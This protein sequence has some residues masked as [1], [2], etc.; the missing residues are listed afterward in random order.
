MPATRHPSTSRA[1]GCRT[2]RRRSGA[3]RT[4]AALGGVLLLAGCGSDADSAGTAPPTALTTGL[5]VADTAAPTLESSSGTA[6]RPRPSLP[7]RTDDTAGDTTGASAATDPAATEPI[8]TAPP[9]TTVAPAT[10]TAPPTTAVPATAAAPATTTG[11]TRPSRTIPGSVPTSVPGSLPA[12]PR[13]GYAEGDPGTVSVALSEPVAISG[14]TPVPVSCSV[15]ALTYTASFSGAAV[16][17]GVSVSA[18]ITAAPYRGPGTYP[19]AGSLS[20]TLAD[21]Q[22]VTV[23]IAAQVTVA[24]DLAGSVTLDVTSTSGV[25]VTGSLVWHCSA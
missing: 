2:T 19:G 15:T 12:D 16:T 21:G 23:P 18:S 13:A 7:P 4:L 6:S 17:A 1:P 11:S 25:S 22:N 20:V 3:V 14:W 5:S 9:A 8:T 10:T 24:A